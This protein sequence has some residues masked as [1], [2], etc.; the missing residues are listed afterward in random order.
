MATQAEINKA[1]GVA[2]GN[3]TTLQEKLRI[4]SQSL[5]NINPAYQ[6]NQNY[7]AKLLAQQADLQAQI[8]TTKSSVTA[9]VAERADVERQAP[10]APNPTSAPAANNTVAETAPAT[11]E[12]P[13]EASRLAA[14]QALNNTPLETA[15]PEVNQYISVITPQG[16]LLFPD[17]ATY[18]AW[19]NSERVAFAT[20]PGGV[21]YVSI[22]PQEVENSTPPNVGNE[23]PEVAYYQNLQQENARAE[24]AQQ[25][26]QA[27]PV[28]PS[29]FPYQE[30]VLN[31]PGTAVDDGS[32]AGVEQQVEILN[33]QSQQTRQARQ[34]QP[35]SADWRVRISLAPGANYLYKAQGGSSQGREIPGPGILA[36]LAKT[37][38]VVFPYTPTIETSYVAKY[39][40]SELV[41]SNYR[42]QFYSN[43]YVDA[44]NIRGIFTAQDTSEAR[45]LLAVIHFFRSVTKMFYGKDQQAGT[46]PPLVY[47]SGFGQY[48]FN[49]HPCVVSSFQYHLP[50]DVDYIRADG[51][52]NIGIDLLNRA[53]RSSGPSLN[54]ALGFLTAKLGI[55]GLFPGGV[56]KVPSQSAVKS[57]ISNTTNTNSTYV[58][59]KMEISIQ[60][61]PIQT[62]NQV[63]KQFSLQGFANGDLLKGGFW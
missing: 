42:G 12:D 4:V 48:Q 18:N 25:E 15:P 20:G 21:Q 31:Q 36:P 2:E 37:D 16:S 49:E 62:R 19:S 22:V 54:G 58:P 41:H 52:N 7:I 59:T 28:D 60:L 9:L 38:G 13:Y 43:S 39:Q 45:Y 35:S 29:G 32:A 33:A 10:A 5:D 11:E 27:A 8:T 17:Q 24:L 56:A 30:P 63:S 26:A 50:N 34:N 55:N 47:L 3:L 53:D 23:D 1:I 46:P 51:F 6:A 40:N 44:I 57:S 14:E 61:L